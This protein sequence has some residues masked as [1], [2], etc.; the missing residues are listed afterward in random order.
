ML[1]NNYRNNCQLRGCTREI[2]TPANYCLERKAQ[3]T[4]KARQVYYNGPNGRAYTPAF[5]ELY[6]SGQMPAENFSFNP[7][8]IE[9]D[10]FNIGTCN[11]ENPQNPVAQRFKDNL[12][13]VS[14]FQ[15][16]KKE[17]PI[18]FYP[19]LDQRPSICR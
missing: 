10:L 12:P 11:L 4:L 5:P 9:S 18:I 17:T 13:T 16:P 1:N 3:E 7:V 6:N 8:D 2:N 14:F 15:T 19:L